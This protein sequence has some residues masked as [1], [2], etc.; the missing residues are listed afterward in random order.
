MSQH[1]DTSKNTK[2]WAVSQHT[3]T[4]KNTKAWAVSQHTDTSKNTLHL[5]IL[6]TFIYF[7]LYSCYI[8]QVSMPATLGLYAAYID[9]E[10]TE[11]GQ[12]ISYFFPLMYMPEVV[13][14]LTVSM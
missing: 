3:D 1:T 4:S 5:V 14:S 7:A 11:R 6:V 9:I 2:A 12:L 10:C 8:Y 13:L